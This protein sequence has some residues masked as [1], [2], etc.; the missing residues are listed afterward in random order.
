MS[1]NCTRFRVT[2]VL[3]ATLCIAVLTMI[4]TRGVHTAVGFLVASVISV[5]AVLEVRSI[6]PVSVRV[7]GDELHVRWLW[8]RTHR[9]APDEVR[10]MR[11]DIDLENARFLVASTTLRL[12]R[13][14]AHRANE[15]LAAIEAMCTWAA[16][17]CEDRDS[18]SKLR[19]AA[20]S[21]RERRHYIE[22]GEQ[23]H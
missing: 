18:T 21:A 22:A 2:S 3:T 5:V 6:P 11:V 15:P 17:V 12:F 13:V 7:D 14:E 1:G 8:G 10:K 20:K 9:I 4:A 16:E 19:E 23:R